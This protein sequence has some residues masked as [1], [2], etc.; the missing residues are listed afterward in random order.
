[1]D[2]VV[3]YYVLAYRG[4]NVHPPPSKNEKDMEPV[5]VTL[6][7]DRVFTEAIQLR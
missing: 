1:M 2:T 6:F 5:N 3:V 7:G 4:L